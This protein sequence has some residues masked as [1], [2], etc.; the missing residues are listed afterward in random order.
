MVCRLTVMKRCPGCRRDYFD[1][2]LLYCLDD[3]TAL[4]EGPATPTGV[5]TVII[6]SSGSGNDA[7]PA[8]LPTIPFERKTSTSPAHDL[9]FQGKF[10]SVR[11]NR[12]DNEKAIGL[13]ERAVELDPNHALS[14][15]ELART[16]GLKYFY[17]ES[18]NKDLLAKSHAALQRAFAIDPDLAAAHEVKGCLLWGPANGFPH[19]QV[20]TAFRTALALDPNL[21]EAHNWLGCVYFHIGLLDKARA[22]LQ[23][24]LKLDP[25]KNMARFHIAMVQSY[26]GRYKDALQALRSLPAELNPSLIGSTRAWCLLNI[27]R[28][29]EAADLVEQMLA[30]Y[31][32]DVGGQFTGLRAMLFASRRDTS[33]AESAIAEAIEKG[34]GFGHFHHTTHYVAAAYALM[35][36]PVEA[37]RYLEQTA[38]DGFPCYPLFLNDPNLDPIRSE[39][40]FQEFIRE[41]E[42]IW[43]TRVR[44]V[45]EAD[46]TKV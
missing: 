7:D 23:T 11:E 26:A 33:A 44:W 42:A 21:V 1:D 6:S 4:L 37:V 8:E 30:A 12:E 29:D 2:S 41:Q 9:Y 40:R 17:F 43:E 39:P 38:D 5:R 46:S 28:V 27:G 10:Y 25:S 3:G 31:P 22:E 14:W 24:T 13:F 35:E 36:R 45:R 19:E 15:A 34:H 16:Y 32:A 20:I 18:D